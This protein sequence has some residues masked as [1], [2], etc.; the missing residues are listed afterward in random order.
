MG[1]AYKIF[2]RQVPAY[3]LSMA[4]FGLIGAIVVA[5][6]SGKKPAEA[7]P[8]IAAESSDEEKFIMDYLKKAEAESK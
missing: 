2:G 4:T 5:G 3:Q 1:S 6:T 8:P 7:K